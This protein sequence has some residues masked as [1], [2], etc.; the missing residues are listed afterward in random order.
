MCA[1]LA[2]CNDAVLCDRVDL[3]VASQ[4]VDDEAAGERA[5]RRQYPVALRKA[6][7]GNAHG[8]RPACDH[9]HRVFV[10]CECIRAVRYAREMA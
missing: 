5:K 1:P 4:V 7:A 2:H 10:S 8:V 9:V 6:K 3:R